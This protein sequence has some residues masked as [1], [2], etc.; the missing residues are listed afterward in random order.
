MQQELEKINNSSQKQISQEDEK[1][2]AREYAAPFGV[3]LWLV[4]KRAFQ[5]YWR[6]PVYI[7]SKLALNIIAGL[8]IG[9]SF[10][11][12]G[13][14]D[15]IQSLQNLL[16]AIF[17][18]LVIS[19]SLAQQLQ[20]VFINLRSLYE[21]RERPS[22]LYSWPVALV[23]SIIVEIP[24]NILGGTLFWACWYWMTGFPSDSTKAGYHW[25]LYM[26]F[27]LY[28]VSFAQAIGKSHP[29]FLDIEGDCSVR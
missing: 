14:N 18:S 26:L 12:Q 16:F 27:E 9:S 2:G 5:S 17:M 10:W 28:F 7:G 15:T 6:S 19:T 22:K 23:S 3:Q 24:W 4:T 13:K 11:A 1:R 8:F 25:G 21:A 29:S 20:P